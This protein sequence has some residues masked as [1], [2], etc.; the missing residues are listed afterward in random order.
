[1]E[2]NQDSRNAW[3][4]VE[5]TGISVFLTER[6]EQERQPSFVPSKNIAQREVLSLLQQVL[7]QSMQEE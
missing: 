4:F 3:D 1:M 6:Q 7:Q 5:H 2:R